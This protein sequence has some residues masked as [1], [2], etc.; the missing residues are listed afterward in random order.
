MLA[1]NTIG[2][3][4]IS[5]IL[6]HTGCIE[7][8]FVERYQREAK[9]SPLEKQLKERDWQSLPNWSKLNLKCIENYSD[10]TTY[11]NMGCRVEAKA[12]K[13]IKLKEYFSIWRWQARSG[14]Q[15]TD[16]EVEDVSQ[17][18]PNF[19]VIIKVPSTHKTAHLQFHAINGNNEHGKLETPIF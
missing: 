5:K 3:I 17:F 2:I 12:G 7:E 11:R 6:L 13:P 4:L 14:G 19:H 18:H 1:I 16:L 8:S 15:K 9:Q 10:Q